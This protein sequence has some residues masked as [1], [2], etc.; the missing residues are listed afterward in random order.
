MSIIC[1][2]ATTAVYPLVN[3][4][5]AVPAGT[6]NVNALAVSPLALMEL[7]NVGAVPERLNPCEAINPCA[8]AFTVAVWPLHVTL[9]T[10]VAEATA[11]SM[12]IAIIVFIF[13]LRF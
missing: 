3:V 9:V 2:A 12:R 11:D 1:L 7:L 10:V 13:V 6:V 8:V 5:H 4:E